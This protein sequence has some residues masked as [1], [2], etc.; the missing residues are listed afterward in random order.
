VKQPIAVLAACLLLTACGDGPAD[1]AAQAACRAYGGTP[2]TSAQREEQRATASEQA[3]RAAEAD[4]TYAALP[5]D[6]ADAWSRSDGMAA[7]QNSGQ[8]VSGDELDAYFAADQRVRSDCADA[9][10]ELGPLEP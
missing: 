4:D 3:Q 2:S 7:A 8:A 10:E 1:D 5:R 9:G 6:I